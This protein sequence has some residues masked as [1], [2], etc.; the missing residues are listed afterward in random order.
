MKIGILTYHWV[1]NFGANLQTLSTVGY[2]R[3]HGYDPV[4]INWVPEDLKKHYDETTTPEMVKVFN[5]FQQN[6]YPL[7]KLCKD[8]KDIAEVIKDE[9]IEKVFLGA[10]T[11]FKLRKP[12]YNIKTR[13][14]IVPFST[15]IF[16]NPFWGEFLNYVNVPIVGYSIATNMTDYKDFPE[17]TEEINKYLKRF[18]KL[19]VRDSYTREMVAGFTKNTLIPNITPDPVFGFNENV[20]L[21]DAERDILAKFELPSKYYLLCMPQP[22]HLRLQDWAVQLN[23]L[24]KK[25]NATLFELPRQ[26]GGQCFNIPQLK[27]QHITPLEW[28]VIIKNSAGYIGG[29]M[30]PLVSCIHNSVPFYCLDYYGVAPRIF[31]MKV[32]GLSRLFVAKKSSKAYQIV[33]DCGLAEY[34][35]NVNNKF[36]TIPSPY[37]VYNK[38]K[39]YNKEQLKMVSQQRLNF[40]KQTVKDILS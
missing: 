15:D 21:K 32:K 30:H 19:T 13:S 24:V 25:D 18:D 39:N 7:T 16:P 9:K 5:D 31:G 8:S 33:N 40:Y 34:Y 10:D 17:Q 12:V 20:D 6:Y 4:V 23:E 11:L 1:Y 28:Y 22:Y 2:F 36:S 26:N 38:I 14:T 27:Y 35:F 3:K 37:E 29:L